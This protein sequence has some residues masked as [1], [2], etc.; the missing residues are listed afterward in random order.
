MII[1]AQ[2][3]LYIEMYSPVVVAAV[4]FVALVLKQNS[5]ANAFRLY[6]LNAGGLY[7]SIFD[8]ASIQTGFMFGVYGFV[9]GKT[10]GF[11]ADVR[12]TKAMGRF[13][14]YTWMATAIGFVLT[15]TSMPLIVT[16][17]NFESATP[18]V[19]LLIC[20]WFSLFLW[21]FG[22]NSYLS[23]YRADGIGLEPPGRIGCQP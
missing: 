10:D 2:S 22:C 1:N 14:H 23:T 21:G 19:R 17:P 12:N 4:V 20:A 11:I 8:W 15:L 16:S 18:A 7:S 5:I 13:V 3:R 9:V 6:E